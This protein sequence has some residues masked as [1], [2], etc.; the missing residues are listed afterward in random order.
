MRKT[1]EAKHLVVLNRAFVGCAFPDGIIRDWFPN[2][3]PTPNHFAS[4]GQSWRADGDAVPPRCGAVHTGRRARRRAGPTRGSHRWLRRVRPHTKPT[5]G[6]RS[7]S[8]STTSPGSAAPC[9]S[10]PSRTT[11]CPFSTRGA[12]SQRR[13]HQHGDPVGRTEHPARRTRR[14]GPAPVRNAG[15][16]VH[17]LDPRPAGPARWHALLRS[18]CCTSGRVDSRPDAHL[19]AGR[20]VAR[21]AWIGCACVLEGARSSMST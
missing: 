1:A 14:P 13:L 5:T 7:V 17:V 15:R 12:V 19:P 9:T 8:T 21:G 6:R 18:R 20:T 3:S 10:P 2:S 16:V 11:G 4:C